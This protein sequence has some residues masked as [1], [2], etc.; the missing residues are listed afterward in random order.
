[1]QTFNMDA[2]LNIQVQVPEKFLKDMREACVAE[3]ASEFFKQCQQMHPDDDDEFIL[4]ILRNGFKHQIR[5]CITNLCEVS[6]I[7]G[8]FSPVQ[9][10]DR[11]P[12]AN[13]APVLA[14]QINE[15]IQ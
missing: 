11:T 15:S 6:G 4:M 12:P 2:T 10:R 9:V 5:Y 1:M 8:T 3:D 14:S 7:G 13:V